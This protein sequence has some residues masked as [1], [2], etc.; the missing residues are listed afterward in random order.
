[1]DLLAAKLSKAGVDVCKALTQFP[2]GNFDVDWGEGA[3][4]F[5]PKA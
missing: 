1:V 2:G 3:V 4:R 5:S